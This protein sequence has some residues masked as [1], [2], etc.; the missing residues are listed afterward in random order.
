MT[1]PLDGRTRP[2][3]ELNTFLE[4]ITETTQTEDEVT[5]EELINEGESEELQFK[6]SLR[7]DFD[8]EM[9]NKRLENFA[10]KTIAAFA[11][12]QGG[13]LLTGVTD[14]GVICGL[15]DDSKALGGANKDKCRL[16][17]NNLSRKHFGEAFTATHVAA[18]FPEILNPETCCV[19]VRRANKPV[20]VMLN[21][22][23][24]HRRERFYVRSGNAPP[25]LPA[26]EIQAYCSE[27]FN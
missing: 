18:N 12:G 17:L 26:S 16:H 24:G 21:G 13:T 10:I 5:L 6:A 27:R 8:K 9:V 23:N 14:D 11:N 15:E 25:E 22:K 4:G 1:F 20:Y 7:W 19:D 3:N 2:S